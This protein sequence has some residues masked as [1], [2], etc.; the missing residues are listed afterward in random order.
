M[1]RGESSISALDVVGG[2][3]NDFDVSDYGILYQ[4]V[5]KKSSF[6][7]SDSRRSSNLN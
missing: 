4:L 1:M 3:T 5:G 2:L 7:V 6:M